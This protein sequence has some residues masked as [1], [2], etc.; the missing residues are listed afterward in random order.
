MKPQR[1]GRTLKIFHFRIRSGGEIKMLKIYLENVELG[2][3]CVCG[4]EN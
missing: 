4:G 2:T 1:V 3:T